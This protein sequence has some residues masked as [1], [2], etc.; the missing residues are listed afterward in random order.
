MHALPLHS[1]KDLCVVC[2]VCGVHMLA[3]GFGFLGLR[4]GQRERE[5]KLIDPV[6]ASSILT[7]EQ[8]ARHKPSP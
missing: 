3:T 5:S 4:L 6:D 8:A 1:W 7:Q 2:V